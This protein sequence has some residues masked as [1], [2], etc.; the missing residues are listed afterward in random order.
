MQLH[1]EKK[2]RVPEPTKF[3]V[4]FETPEIR[5]RGVDAAADMEGKRVFLRK[6]GS[7]VIDRQQLDRLKELDIPFK[8]KSVPPQYAPG[9]EK[10]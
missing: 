7:A 4:Q 6:D 9:A 8:I 10:T 2:E 1:K 3:I 5:R